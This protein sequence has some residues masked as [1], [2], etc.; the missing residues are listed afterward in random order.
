MLQRSEKQAWVA[1]MHTE[2]KE[3]GGVFVANYQ[4]LTVSAMEDL[5]SEVRKIGGQAKVARNRLMRLALDKTDYAELGDMFKGATLVVY[6][7]ESVDMAKALVNFAK[8]NEA[9]EILGGAV[10]TEMLSLEGVKHYATLP[11]LDELR[12]TIVGLLQ[13]PASKLAR[14]VQAPAGQ[15]ARVF[16]AYAD[17]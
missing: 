12:G 4:G 13:A 5:R 10:G 7:A 6:G 2:M 3:T 17:K 15:L 14:V 9:L 11:S 8:E 16:K 1:D